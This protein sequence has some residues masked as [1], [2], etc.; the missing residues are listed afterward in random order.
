MITNNSSSVCATGNLFNP[1]SNTGLNLTKI[2]QINLQNDYQ[3]RDIKGTDTWIDWLTLNGSITTQDYDDLVDQLLL[4]S[5]FGSNY[6]YETIELEKPI[7]SG[8]YSYN[9]KC[10]SLSGVKLLARRV[11]YGQVHV[12][13]Q[14]SGSTCQRL[15]GRNNG[16][17]SGLLIYYLTKLGLTVSRIDPCWNHPGLFRVFKLI[18]RA[19][20][21]KNYRGIRNGL[22][23][24]PFYASDS[25]S[26]TISL[27][28]RS[29]DL[30]IRIYDMLPK[31]N[32]DIYKWESEIKDYKAKEL[33]QGLNAI[34][35]KYLEG[36][37]EIDF[38]ASMQYRDAHNFAQMVTFANNSETVDVS[39]YKQLHTRYNSVIN[40]YL[41]RCTLGQVDFIDRSKQP[42]NGSVKDC[43]QLRWWFA[44]L[45]S[46]LGSDDPIKLP[47]RK[48]E[49]N[50]QKSHCY[51]FRNTSRHH[52][53]LR[54]GLGVDDYQRY[55]DYLASVGGRRNYTK[56][57]DLDNNLRVAELKQYGIN[58][59]FSYDEL[60]TIYSQYGIAFDRADYY[61]PYESL[62]LEEGGLERFSK[63]YIFWAS[64]EE[65]LQALYEI[66]SN[67]IY[68]IC[69]FMYREEAEMIFS[70]AT[71][72]QVIPDF[73]KSIEY[74]PRIV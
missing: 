68:S 17:G 69:R 9:L 20:K 31:H 23:I 41:R 70:F 40:R 63:S 51:T 12:Q 57:E 37:E 7:R 3:L 74:R 18:K 35:E 53:L 39:D 13:I 29:S 43:P 16:I 24:S 34:I 66:D 26:D 2:T 64:Q 15:L 65:I 1:S 14:L 47:A 45:P 38:I 22:N 33:V 72:W 58:A 19:G 50:L 25:R 21:K 11:N 36:L 54:R 59:L 55:C 30:Y 5:F 48:S 42:S 28:S 32:E 49:T 52:Y 46:V 71:N 10:E 61:P 73:T 60:A 27:G 44:F 8:S 56:A 6:P 62:V 67:I 4:G